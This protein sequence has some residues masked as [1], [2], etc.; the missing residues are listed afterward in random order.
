[1]KK[2]N[3]I[4]FDCETG[5]LR[6]K[7]NPITQI[8]FLAIDCNTLKEIN[9]FETFVKPYDDLVITKEALNYT[10]LKMQDINSGIDKKE[11]LNFLIDFF[12]KC[13]P[14]NRP[15][16]KPVMV[17]H[18]VQYDIGFLKYLFES[19]NKNVFDYISETQI[20]TMSLTKMFNPDATS[21]KLESCCDNVGVVLKD[22]HNAMNDVIATTELFKVYIHKLRQSSKVS[23]DNNSNKQ[24]TKSRNKFQF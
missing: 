22:A 3:Y 19:L 5:G 18:N 14:N 23:T 7:E 24:N 8:G 12:K 1:M 20:D 11:L 17:G 2:A 21:L 10:G 4:I 6:P 9:R 15:E 13:S 16:N